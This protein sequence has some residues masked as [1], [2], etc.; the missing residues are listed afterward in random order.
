MRAARRSRQ[1]GQVALLS[2]IFALRLRASGVT[3]PRSALLDGSARDRDPKATPDQKCNLLG[4]GGGLTHHRL[5]HDRQVDDGR[6]HAEQDREPPHDIVGAGLHIRDAAQ[7]HAEEAADLVA[8][9]CEASERREPARPE[10]HR[11]DPVG[12]RH[13][14]KPKQPHGR[15]EQNRRGRRDGECDEH[16]HRGCACKIDERQ[17]VAFGH[18]VAKPARG[19]RA[20]YVEQAD[21]GDSPAAD[22]RGQPAVDQERRHVHG[23]E[24]ELEAAGEI[25][26]HE[27]HIGAV[28]D[29]LAQ[30]LAE[31]LLRPARGRARA[32]GN[33]REC[34]RG[35]QHQ[36]HA[37]GKHQERVLPAE[38][39]HQKD[40]ERRIEKLPERAGRGA[41]AEADQ[42][43]VL[44]QELAERREHDGERAAR[45]AE[46]DEHAGG[47]IEHAGRA[48]LRHQREPER[49][50]NGAAAQHTQRAEAVGEGARER[51]ADAPE[52]ILKRDGEP[53]YAAI[54]AVDLR[55][56]REEQAERRAWPEAQHGDQAA[57]QH[58]HE[59]RSPAEGREALPRGRCNSHV[60]NPGLNTTASRTKPPW[61]AKS[62]TTKTAATASQPRRGPIRYAREAPT[63][64]SLPAFTASLPLPQTNLAHLCLRSMHGSRSRVGWKSSDQDLH[65]F[66]S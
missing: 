32:R 27:Q 25:A 5:L 8:E 42:P 62:P 44:G 1:R 66:C 29:R 20:E 14:R 10:H 22:L 21:G 46:A 43:P 4:R 53:E 2:V 45:E 37:R 9:E 38:R 55:H 41:G 16:E 19:E 56:R 3:P 23:D 52:Q 58:D 47:E 6:Q 65:L 24:G 11:D 17:Q 26:E 63:I 12:R 35:R 15:A 33:G 18:H 39:A 7:P 30:G 54:P 51:L 13:G 28:A 60:L 48:R 31:R 64:P 61:D 49:I 57:A 34:E 40:C 36:Q 59:R 50:E